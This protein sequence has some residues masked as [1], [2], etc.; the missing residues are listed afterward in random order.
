[1]SLTAEHKLN[2][3]KG[4]KGKKHSAERRLK[5]ANAHKGLKVSEETKQKLRVAHTKH[6]MSMTPTYISWLAMKQRCYNKN[7]HNYKR[8]GSRGIKVCE[9][10]V[11]SFEMFYNDMGERPYGKTLD[12]IDND[13]NYELENCRWATSIEQNNNTSRTKQVVINGGVNE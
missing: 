6:N 11:K 13:G 8:C 3:S 1:M 10:W 7:H 4:L 2:I 12:R 5:S 9:E